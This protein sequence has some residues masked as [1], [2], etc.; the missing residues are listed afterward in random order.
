PQGLMGASAMG[1]R[2]A[3][4]HA[5]GIAPTMLPPG[6]AHAAEGAAG[7]QPS[8]A[9]VTLAVKYMAERKMAMDLLAD[10]FI[11]LPGGYGTLDEA[12]EAIKLRQIGVH[13][14]PTVF[15]NA[16]RF[17]SPLRPLLKRMGQAQ[18]VPDEH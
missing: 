4:G 6:K 14:K 18:F 9:T 8:P 3:G 5:I 12:F 16:N 17:W 7:G 10:A 11:A 15:L 13:D 1:A 2:E